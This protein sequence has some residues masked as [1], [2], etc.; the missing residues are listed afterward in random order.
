MNIAVET[1]TKRT[2][3]PDSDSDEEWVGPKIDTKESQEATE[4]E[5]AHNQQVL[6]ESQV[7]TKKRKSNIVVKV[8]NL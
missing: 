7:Q 2:L 5:P 3:S 6:I 8:K 1:N 4:L